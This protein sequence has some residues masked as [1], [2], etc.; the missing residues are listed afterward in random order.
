MECKK[1]YRVVCE[2]VD[3]MDNDHTDSDEIQV[4]ATS[5]AS[6]IAAARKKWRLT[7]GAEWPR[8]R[9]EKTWILTP[10]RTKEFA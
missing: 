6:A 5:A 3:A 7:I 8:C 10:S 4:M 9:L 2:W 1:S